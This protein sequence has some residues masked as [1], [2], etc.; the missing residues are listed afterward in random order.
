M[1]RKMIEVKSLHGLT[2][3]DLNF[4]TNELNSNYSRIVIQT[5][6]MRYSG[7]PTQ[8]IADILDKCVTTIVSN[9]NNCN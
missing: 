7:V 8:V 1:G 2:I 6:I 4:I 3:D 9:I 5:V